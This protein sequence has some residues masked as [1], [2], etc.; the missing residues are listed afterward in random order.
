MGFRAAGRDR[1]ASRAGLEAAYGLGSA[2]GPEYPADDFEALLAREADAINLVL[3]IGDDEAVQRVLTDVQTRRMGRVVPAS[4][5]AAAA[6][7]AATSVAG[8]TVLA[9]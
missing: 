7:V 1:A 8:V 2:R 4:M 6:I 9:G 3:P 5:P